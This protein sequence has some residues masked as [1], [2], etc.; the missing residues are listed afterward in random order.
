MFARVAPSPC[1]HLLSRGPVTPVRVWTPLSGPGGRG[2]H[3]PPLWSPALAP[4][5]RGPPS[6]WLGAPSV[7]RALLATSRVCCLCPGGSKSPGPPGSR[8][9]ARLCS[10]DVGTKISPPSC[11]GYR[12]QGPGSLS[13]EVSPARE[14][15]GSACDRQARPPSPHASCP[16][17][18]APGRHH[19][20]TGPAQ[21]LGLAFKVKFVSTVLII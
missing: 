7:A 19:Q 11:S 9:R 15:G 16:I 20:H 2:A 14:Q 4:S 6:P 3:L 17:R 1:A 10:A 13:V 8:P 21:G 5:L 12:L 18:A